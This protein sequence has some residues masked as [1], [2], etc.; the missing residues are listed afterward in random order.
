M[1]TDKGM[2]A[3]LDAGFVVIPQFRTK[4]SRPDHL[5]RPIL[6]W[7]DY[8]LRYSWH[9]SEVFG[10]RMEFSCCQCEFADDARNLERLC[11][12]MCQFTP[13]SFSFAKLFS[14]L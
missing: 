11:N 1:G 2:S 6:P 3:R 4:R 9:R 8:G 12:R 10:D 13:L 7:P 5:F 14:S